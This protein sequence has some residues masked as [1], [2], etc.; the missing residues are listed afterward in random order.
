MAP[1]DAPPEDRR[2]AERV[3]VNAAFGG[4]HGVHYVRDLSE[5]GVFLHIDKAPP[6]GAVVDLC[7]TVIADDPVVLR[8]R[9]RIVRHQR[10][11]S[12]VGVEFTR[13]NAD[14]KARIRDVVDVNRP[15][16]SGPSI[17]PQ[18]VR[19]T[20]DQIIEAHNLELGRVDVDDMDDEA[21]EAADTLMRLKPIDLEILEE[22][23]APQ[24]EEDNG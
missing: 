23:D 7:F 20:A 3:E 4:V 11:P 5:N 22:P 19:R 21:S 2:R 9:G 1:D 16:D 8:A 12:G 10:E 17:E 13:I 6:V 24:D 15:Q 18:T 14:M